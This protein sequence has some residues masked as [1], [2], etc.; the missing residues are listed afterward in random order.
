MASL[1][2]AR[3]P[4][5]VSGF[6]GFGAQY[7]Q[8]VYAERSRRAGVGVTAENVKVMEGRVAELA[9]Q[10]ARVFFSADALGDE[11][12]LKSFRS[13]VALAQETAGAINVTLQGLGPKVLAKHPNLIAEFAQEV[14]QLLNQP[15]PVS[16]L[17]WVTLRNEPNGSNPMPKKLYA[18]CYR[19]FDR[20]ATRLG[21]AS[22]VGLMGGDLL[23]TSQREWFTFLAN[24]PELRRII[25]AYS[26][27]VYWQFDEPSKIDARLHDVSEIRHSLAALRNKPFYV[28]ECGTRGD[29]VHGGMREDPGFFTDGRR[30]C[31]TN[32][33]AF[34]RIW[35]ALQA[36]RH[37][38]AGVV[39][40]DAY[41]AAYDP[42]DLMHYSLLAG[43]GERPPWKV[44]PAYRA[45]RLLSRAVDP[46]WNV[47]PVAGGT[48]TQL[49]VA[50]ADPEHPAQ[51]SIIGLDRAGASLEKATARQSTYTIT[52]LPPNTKFQLCH[53]NK[54]GNGQNSFDG[55]AVSNSSGAVSISVPLHSAF[56]LTTRR[57]K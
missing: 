4:V 10:L 19:D 24:D 44:R 37:G 6:D 22:R 23:Q 47:L 27:H 33:N 31:E 28:M 26:I 32:V 3:E 51:L 35:F 45:L 41:F 29:K 17:R 16:K 7:N 9:P 2:L 36:A 8:N 21:F 18:R 46:G 40:W 14:A 34:Q 42:K 54:T 1:T 50:F 39:T 52:G 49:V 15:H 56:V 25:K 5:V 20:E 12:L 30:I 43:P 48:D 38:F 53:W 13:T 11:D 55:R 57:M